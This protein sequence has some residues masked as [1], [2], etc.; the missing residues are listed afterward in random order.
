MNIIY[1]HPLFNAQEWLI[2]IKQR[3]ERGSA[4]VVELPVHS[5]TS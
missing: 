4:L 1:Y 2:G 5:R 3:A